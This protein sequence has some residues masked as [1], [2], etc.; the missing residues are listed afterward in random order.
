[1]DMTSKKKWTD[2][3]VILG[4]IFVVS[5]PVMI[6]GAIIG[7]VAFVW[8]SDTGWRVGMTIAAIGAVPF[9]FSLTLAQFLDWE[10]IN[11]DSPNA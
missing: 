3:D 11:K 8:G 4:L 1:M 7:I 6:I 5:A 9:I 2:I 10:K